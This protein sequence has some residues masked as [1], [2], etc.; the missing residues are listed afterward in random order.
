MSK[1]HDESAYFDHVPGS[2]GDSSMI[3]AA[4]GTNR[5][6]SSDLT[7]HMDRNVREDF[8]PSDWSRIV[9]RATC[10]V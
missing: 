7:F 6:R 2:K 1:G 10:S 3:L 4:F 5:C 9:N 8:L